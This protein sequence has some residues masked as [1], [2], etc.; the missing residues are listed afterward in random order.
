MINTIAFRRL[1]RY[2]QLAIYGLVKHKSP[3]LTWHVFKIVWR[4][5]RAADKL[6]KRIY[7]AIIGD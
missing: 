4:G 3:S 7:D 5:N 2:V 1:R 6:S